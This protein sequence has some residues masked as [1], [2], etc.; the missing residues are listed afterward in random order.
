MIEEAKAAVAVA[1]GFVTVAEKQWMK[2]PS[3][4]SELR[5]SQ[6]CNHY[7]SMRGGHYTAFVHHG[8]GQWYEFDDSRV[9][10]SGLEKIK[11]S[12]AYRLFYGRVVEYRTLG[13]HLLIKSFE[14]RYYL[15]SLSKHL[16]P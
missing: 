1:A 10:P 8:D 9:Y 7:G 15:V 6:S 13:H 4:P 5:A 3:L 12:A 2:R 14:A 16:Q 11:T